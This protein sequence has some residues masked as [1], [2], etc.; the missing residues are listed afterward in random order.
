MWK[1]VSRSRFIRKRTFDRGRV[2]DQNSFIGLHANIQETF[3]PQDSMELAINVLIRLCP[4]PAENQ[5]SAI[6]L[7]AQSVRV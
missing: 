6:G 5:N 3:M 2:I 1:R 4:I 7:K